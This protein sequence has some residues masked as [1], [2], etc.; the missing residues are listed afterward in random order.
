MNVVTVVFLNIASFVVCF[1]LAWR[2]GFG[3]WSSLGI[4]SFGGAFLTLAVLALVI[5]LPP[6]LRRGAQPD[7]RGMP[8]FDHNR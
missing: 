6:A 4:G 8:R 5:Y 7:P 3:F 2:A 1:G